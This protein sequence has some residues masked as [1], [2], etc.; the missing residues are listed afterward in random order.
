MYVE[1]RK[2]WLKLYIP[3]RSAVVLRKVWKWHF[4]KQF[5][6]VLQLNCLILQ[7]QRQE[8]KNIYGT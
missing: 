5:F 2:E 6:N 4:F 1:D 3:A 7:P 8:F